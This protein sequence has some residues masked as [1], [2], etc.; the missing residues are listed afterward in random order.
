MHVVVCSLDIVLG[1]EVGVVS[2]VA[3]FVG[4]KEVFFMFP[5]AFRV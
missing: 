3:M 5:Y 1:E 2:W 4:A